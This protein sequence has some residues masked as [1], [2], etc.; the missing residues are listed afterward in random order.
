[1]VE[2]KKPDKKSTKNKSIQDN[3]PASISLDGN[4]KKKVS[5]KG[6][7]SLNYSDY[8]KKY[9][10][11]KK[12]DFELLA[13]RS[14]IDT[15]KD[16]DAIKDE[17]KAESFYAESALDYTKELQ[18]ESYSDHFKEMKDIDKKNVVISNEM[19][20]DNK[21]EEEGEFVVRNQY[22][23]SFNDV[24][25]QNQEDDLPDF[26]VDS[27]SLNFDLNKSN[28]T[29]KS[30]KQKLTSPSPLNSNFD[31][32]NNERFNQPIP[33]RMY[34]PKGYV[35]PM[36]P[37]G[38]PPFNPYFNPY[39]VP[40]YYYP[41]MPPG[42]TPH[43]N[44]NPYQQP[45]YLNQQNPYFNKQQKD[46]FP[47]QTNYTEQLL[48]FDP[49]ASTTELVPVNNYN[50][51][52]PNQNDLVVV[53]KK[54]SS[55]LTHII[56]SF[57][58]RM[59]EQLRI[60]SK[61]NE[62]IERLQTKVIELT[63]ERTTALIGEARLSTEDFLPT[64]E[65]NFESVVADVVQDEPKQE[66]EVVAEVVTK[67]P[68]V[69]VVTD[70]NDIESD[71]PIVD[72]LS[73]EE[74]DLIN[75][76]NLDQELAAFEE[77]DVTSLED[78]LDLSLLDDEITDSIQPQIKY[79]AP[80]VPE[81][82]VREEVKAEEP[83][84]V[85][86]ESQFDLELP[87]PEVEDNQEVYTPN[88]L[89]DLSSRQPE[90]IKNSIVPT[91]VMNEMFGD[92]QKSDPARR[93]WEAYVGNPEYGFYNNKTWNWKGKF[94][95]LQ[96]WIPFTSDQEVP[97][98]GTKHVILSSIKASERKKLWKELIDDPVYGH[99]EG[100]SKV[101]IWHGVFDQELNWI[102][103]PTHDFKTEEEVVAEKQKQSFPK[104]KDVSKKT[105]APKVLKTNEI[106][107][108]SDLHKMLLDD[109]R[110]KK[111]IGNVEYGYYDNDGVWIWTG[112]FDEN[113]EFKPDQVDLEVASDDLQSESNF[114][115]LFDSWKKNNQNNLEYETESKRFKTVKPK[116]VYVN[117]QEQPEDG[118]EQQEEVAPTKVVK[119]E[120]IKRSRYNKPTD[121]DL[122]ILTYDKAK[123]HN[124]KI[125]DA[126][127]LRESS[128][129]QAP[130]WLEFVGN[131]EYGHYNAKG[132]WI[133]DGYFDEQ[134]EFVSTR[135]PD[136][137]KQSTSTVSKTSILDD[138]V[139]VDEYFK[140][141]NKEEILHYTPK[142]KK[143]EPVVE[144]V[145]EEVQPEAEEAEEF[146]S[147]FIGD[148]N[149]GYYNDNNV[150]V[151]SGYFNE[152]NQFVPDE[153]PR[154]NKLLDE[155]V[156]L[157]E[158]QQKEQ[159]LLKA[160]VESELLAKQKAIQEQI[161]RELELRD[162]FLKEQEARELAL[163]QREQSLNEK[164]IRLK[165]EIVKLKQQALKNQEEAKK[166]ALK[167]QELAEQA[168][169]V[170]AA[171]KF[172]KP[173][174][175]NYKSIHQF[176]E[177]VS[178]IS[179]TPTKP[180]E[181]EQPV[182]VDK[183]TV[184]PA[185]VEQVQ[186]VEQVAAEPVVVEEVAVELEPQ[187]E[188]FSFEPSAVE[189]QVEFVVN[190]NLADA[191]DVVVV[192]TNQVEL[193]AQQ[194]TT[195]QFAQQQVVA[196]EFSPQPVE[197]KPQ[198][199]FKEEL[200]LAE[201]SP[202]IVS[203]EIDLPAV[204]ITKPDLFAKQELD[205]SNVEVKLADETSDSEVVS[206]DVSSV[207]LADSQFSLAQEQA[208]V[209]PVI[210]EEAIDQETV[211]V[212]PVVEFE[213]VQLQELDVQPIVE[214]QPEYV[215][216][217]DQPTPVVEE[218]VEEVVEVEPVLE[219]VEAQPVQ[220]EVVVEEQVI[221][222]Q[223]EQF[224]EEVQVEPIHEES[225]VEE[226]VPEVE[227]EIQVESV[228]EETIE[229]QVSEQAHDEVEVS[230]EE[231]VQPEVESVHEEVEAQ[232]VEESVVEEES[233]Y[234]EAVEQTA[235]EVE[236]VVEEPISEP[237]HDE[238]EY[239][240]Q[241]Q[242]QPEVESVHEEVAVEEELTSKEAAEEFTPEA[243]EV[244]AE[245][246]HEEVVEE[247]APE[248]EEA[249]EEPASEEV[250]E[251]VETAVEEEVQ[252]EAEAEEQHEEVQAQPA[253]EEPAIEEEPAA[254][255]EEAEF[256]EKYVG[257]EHY[258]HYDE[259][260]E[261]IWDGYFDEDQNFF[262]NDEE[263]DKSEEVESTSDD[264]DEYVASSDEE[265]SEQPEEEVQEEQEED[266]SLDEISE[267]EQP[268]P[269]IIDFSANA[270]S[271]EPSLEESEDKEAEVQAESE[272]ETQSEESEE[273][274]ETPEEESK[275]EVEAQPE[276]T[277]E[278]ETEFWEKYV[279]DEHYGHYDE[280]EEW[281]WDG[282][283]DEDNNFVR[284]EEEK[285][286]EEVEEAE[287]QS[288][289]EETSPTEAI[290]FDDK[291]ELEEISEDD[292]PEP[293][294]VDFSGNSEVEK[295]VEEEPAVEEPAAEE[296]ASV[297]SELEAEEAQE[298]SSVEEEAATE[299]EAEA[300]A[301]SEEEPAVE[302]EPE[303]EEEAEFWEKYVGDENYG[304]YDDEGEWVWAG[305]FDEDNN[306][307]KND[308]EVEE[309]TA[310]EEPASEETE[311]SESPQEEQAEDEEV[312]ETESEEEPVEEETEDEA[313]SEEETQEDS[314]E[315][316]EETESSEETD[317]DEEEAEESDTDEESEEE[318]APEEI[319]EVEVEGEHYIYADE[320][321]EINFDDY[322]GDENFGYYLEDGEWE[323]YEGD[324]DEDG[325]WFVYV[326]GEAEDVNVEEDIPALKGV[327][328][329]SVDAD[330]WL[331]QFDED[332]ASSIFGDED[333]DEDDDDDYD[334]LS[335]KKKK[336]KK[337]KKAKK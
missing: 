61:Q 308:E 199:D 251:E 276:E 42:F 31:R 245:P 262:R 322:I 15:I 196:E 113:G 179:Q 83:V 146:F 329:E 57:N 85:E 123:I 314:E 39:F 136:E 305:Y 10:E 154:N 53:N 209:E 269:E 73:L 134:F 323:W 318:A 278:E 252:P 69:E 250:H 79:E 263:S 316:A 324:F 317:A 331:S 24:V 66:V 231:E 197:P 143:T 240:L 315:E 94:S 131:E 26:D 260:E 207:E 105:N 17:I 333:S 152:Y 192:D 144:E 216:V 72:I 9:L 234:E 178:E 202:A 214:E 287:E 242:T 58:K 108:D 189:E 190:D 114:S 226:L 227:E 174:K 244:Q 170:K 56:S 290:D 145:V 335:G 60:V 119:N 48:D 137:T 128:S 19:K 293:E 27:S 204:E 165:E 63:E 302:E 139:N 32:F 47:Q 194:F 191:V 201:V 254:Q 265:S 212:E 91:K 51:L 303:A 68:E 141:A 22:H 150:W 282:Y 249:I 55:D 272:E 294:I 328:T 130:F 38:R 13:K 125:V 78:E 153:A 156:S 155:I 206:V 292:Q 59:K 124:D 237:V 138:D 80:V 304:H 320:N 81:V 161:Q 67:Q 243:E 87:E 167:E 107:P 71:D 256:W 97:F 148:K 74:D 112:T 295:E 120:L 211:L 297:E 50:G 247:T 101:W 84:V 298:E 93:F 291:S 176:V 65:H 193:P 271:S 311:E 29:P 203:E 267:D 306:F 187:A 277:Q 95:K 232:P 117:E 30:N 180:V 164:A 1:M 88:Q 44:A 337:A 332:A 121:E 45:P 109:P 11:S 160:K 266:S 336:N 264:K 200:V 253:D 284:N 171:T 261:W 99:F 307:I 281:I 2:K 327:D 213:D 288:A 280:D 103:D 21:K 14:S 230:I 163:K 49:F 309:E 268:E 104:K 3:E 46:L 6:L 28:K 77:F 132:D 228:V 325:N 259:D 54:Q 218:F 126:S 64:T 41:P 255:E 18:D 258:G 241:E 36:N 195:D 248:V 129:Q 151:W 312:E 133:F 16:K 25:T 296:E 166:Q 301:E 169:Q 239:V 289:E 168:K 70:I 90:E 224:Q 198:F 140:P 157:A 223:P 246:A 274:T 184:E 172:I 185:V 217:V 175:D 110:Y 82:V 4:S 142:P 219:E 35:R 116:V 279:G 205:L 181:V 229:E 102:P 210:V 283:F 86:K 92:K 43:P 149:Y 225:V 135:K 313:D 33:S 334:L 182:E 75:T 158:Q 326:Q 159:D 186:V 76:E 127:V 233:T 257:D 7:E 236:Q 310:P 319:E 147:K 238:V 20:H 275:E 40:P 208:Q 270:K 177:G 221:E 300:K 299:E 115:T 162:Q 23:P 118:D 62:M 183:T 8:Y 34:I 98:Y 220:E 5:K 235:P 100:S 111:H 321:G 173:N 12:D 273:E 96:K 52:N 330:D 89:L 286:T 222:Q 188:Q 106:T 122:G 285:E 215:Q 37:Y